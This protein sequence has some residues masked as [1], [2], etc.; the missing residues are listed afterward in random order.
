MISNVGCVEEGQE[1]ECN[2]WK[3]RLERL[4]AD[5]KRGKRGEAARNVEKVF[6]GIFN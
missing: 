5:R 2:V 1:A 6:I 3:R 4:K